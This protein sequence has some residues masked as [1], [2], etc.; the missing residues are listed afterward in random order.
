MAAHCAPRF[1]DRVTLDRGDIVPHIPYPRMSNKPPVVL[2][3][4][5]VARL[6]GAVRNPKHRAVPSTI[7]AAGLGKRATV[8]TLRHSF[9]TH[10]LEGGTDLRLIQT[11]LG[12]R[13]I[14]TT[15]IYTHVSAQRLQD[16]ASP[17]DR[18]EASGLSI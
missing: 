6:L 7:Y 4:E 15:A 13:S 3:A 18:L 9:A 17:F 8:H 2:S 16:T 10:L 11:L 5:G 12:H 14:K 1:L